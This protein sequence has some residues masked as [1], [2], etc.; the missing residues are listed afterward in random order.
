MS[1]A[2]ELFDG[3]VTNY[4]ISREDEMV[5]EL[6]KI[7]AAQ[8]AGNE[9]PPITESGL[10]ILEYLQGCGTSDYLKAK[11]IAEG[12]NW[13][14]RKVSGS[15]RKLTLDGFVDKNGKDPV[16]YAL[17]DKGKEFDVE[18]YKS[19]LVNKKEKE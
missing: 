4:G 11:D 10:A 17:S 18:A 7:L 1:K 19:S 13:S 14:S 9:K 5:V 12:M 6:F 16:I 15:I 8:D 3:I 2:Y